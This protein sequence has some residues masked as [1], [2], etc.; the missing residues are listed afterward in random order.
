MSKRVG[1]VI[2]D[3]H[4]GAIASNEIWNQ[5]QSS[6]FSYAN[7]LDQLDF[8]VIAG[9][10]FDYKLYLNSPLSQ[11]AVRIMSAIY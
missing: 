1:L 7:K 4:V 11:V 2:S 9:D 8:I 5:L 6:F 3:I 10:F